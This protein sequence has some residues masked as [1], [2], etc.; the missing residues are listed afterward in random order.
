MPSTPTVVSENDE[1]PG[2]WRPYEIEE[3]SEHCSREDRP[4]SQ[5]LRNAVDRRELALSEPWSLYIE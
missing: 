1:W 5:R 3:Q 2:S 4:D